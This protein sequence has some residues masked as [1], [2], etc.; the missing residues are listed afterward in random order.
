MTSTSQKPLYLYFD[1]SKSLFDDPNF[2][3][4]LLEW[5]IAIEMQEALSGQA[6]A[7]LLELYMV[8]ES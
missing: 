6:I 4:E 1:F 3:W 5:E 7:R 2:A 8:I